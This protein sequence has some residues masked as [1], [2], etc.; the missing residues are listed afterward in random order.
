MGQ[1]M[2]QSHTSLQ[3]DLE[4]GCAE[5]DTVVGI[6]R[7]MDKAA[8]I[9]GCRMTGGGF[10]GSAVALIDTAARLRESM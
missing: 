5:L 7:N 3:Q 2:Y 8:R 1:L 6:A 9:H 10:G 4:V